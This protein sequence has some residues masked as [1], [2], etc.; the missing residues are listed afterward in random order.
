MPLTPGTRLGAYEVVGVLGAGGMGEVYRARDRK[1]NRDVALKVLPDAFV[2]DPGRVARFTREAHTL[3]ALNH[4]NIAQ[5]HGLE[6]SGNV[7]ALAME[8]VEGEDLSERVFR[9]TI[10][11][12][13][14]LPIAKQIAEALEAAHEQGI[15]HRDLKPANI[16]VSRDGTVKVLDFGLAKL[17]DPALDEGPADA[18]AAVTLTVPSPPMLTS[19]GI[20]L[21]TPA[22]MAPEQAR[23]RGADRRADI[24]AFGCVLYE[25][26]TANR[27][28]RGETVTDIMAAVIHTEPDWSRLPGSTPP[29]VRQLLRRC[30][31][32]DPRRRLQAIGDARVTIEE[33]LSGA[34]QGDAVPARPRWS[35][36]WLAWG[37]AGVLTGATIAGLV[38]RQMTSSTEPP[39][40]VTRFV[41]TLPAGQQLAGASAL[42]LSSDGS[43]LA[44]VAMDSAN[45]NRQIFLRAMDG[46]DPRP[47]AGTEGASAPFFSPDGQWLGFFAD[48]GLKKVPLSGGAPVNLADVTNPTGGAWIDEHTIVFASYLSTLLRVSDAGGTSQALTRFEPGE[49]AHLSP[50]PLPG[51]KAVLFSTES[52]RMS[53]IVVQRIDGGARHDIIQTPGPGA[54]D[55]LGPGYVTY[56]QAGNLMAASFDTQRNRTGTPIAAMPDVRQYS[57]SAAGSLVYVA[58]K[59]P[60]APQA[61]LVWVSRDGMT[62]QSVG[63]PPRLYNQPRLSPEG[64]RVAVDVIGST[65]QVWLYDLTRDIFSRF[66]FGGDNR[67]PV[68]A[69]EGKRLAF[70][71]NRDGGWQIFWKRADGSGDAQP[72]SGG[73]STAA[74]DVFNI[75]CSWSRDGR[76]LAFARLAPAAAAELCVLRVDDE[77][78]TRAGATAPVF[79]RTRAADGAPQLSPDGRWMAYASEESGRREI[80]VQAYPGPGGRWQVSSDG[81]NEPLW[82]ANGRELFYRSGDRMMA[83]EISTDGEFLPGKPRQLF[84]KPYVRAGGGYVRAQYDVSPD[85]QRFLMLKEVEQKPVPLTQIHVVLNWSDELKRRLPR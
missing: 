37:G 20:V 64:G 21:G 35:T 31:Q 79:T 74:P 52:T 29:P 24:W 10:P 4:S 28:F 51:G 75:P 23:G 33:I 13:E 11:S 40:P 46:V 82:S 30:L 53:A 18:N 85:G 34:A 49:T 73:G 9:G 8:L 83:V 59:P 76:L 41:I 15:I 77:S 39:R 32:K 1:L 38:A 12:D 78:T 58:G 5:I 57:V 22:Y 84:E 36:W 27:P 47:I 16:K 62:E 42:A 2:N 63:A 44:Y 69:P 80:Y 26:L 71:S 68:W 81:A 60:A 55:Y 43:Q 17:L 54:P 50:R 25:M 3:A 65:T 66:T 14:A 70:M 61:R 19:V 56:R 7:R 45:A 48:G 72:L 67:H 6:E